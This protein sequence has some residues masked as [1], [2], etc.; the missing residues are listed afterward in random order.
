MVRLI[1]VD[2]DSDAR[3]LLRIYLGRLDRY[4]IVGEAGDVFAAVDLTAQTTPDVIVLDELLPGGPGHDAIPTLKEL[5]P[6]ARI[7]V[8][9]S[10]DAREASLAAGADIFLDKLAGADQVVIALDALIPREESDR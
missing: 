2:D 7:I 5:A 1:I 3:L 10:L 8:W 6:D 9:S 4:E